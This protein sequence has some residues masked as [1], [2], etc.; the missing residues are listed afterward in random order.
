MLFYE[1]K[2]IMHRRYILRARGSVL[3]IVLV[4]I[5]VDRFELRHL[6]KS[7]LASEELTVGEEMMR[8]MLHDKFLK[9]FCL[10]DFGV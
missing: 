10:R 6:V 9:Y 4:T 2:H 7:K 3:I 1:I 5:R 8:Q